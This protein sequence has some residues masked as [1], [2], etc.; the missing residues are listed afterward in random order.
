MQVASDINMT[1]ATI[2]TTNL[3]QKSVE[4]VVNYTSDSVVP[5]MLELHQEVTCVIL[6][7]DVIPA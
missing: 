7:C 4:Y 2:G 5:C 3:S 6:D 1:I